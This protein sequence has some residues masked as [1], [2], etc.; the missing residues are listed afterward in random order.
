MM[1]TDN[2]SVFICLEKFCAGKPGASLTCR[3]LEKFPTAGN[4][5]TELSAVSICGLISKTL[6]FARD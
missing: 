2:S 1:N 6:T 4:P 5:P 3:C